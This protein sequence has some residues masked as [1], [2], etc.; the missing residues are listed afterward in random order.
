[1]IPVFEIINETTNMKKFKACIKKPNNNNYIYQVCYCL[2]NKLSNHPSIEQKELILD[3]LQFLIKNII[4]KKN[5]EFI[6]VKTYTQQIKPRTDIIKYILDQIYDG[7]SD[8]TKFTDIEPEDEKIMYNDRDII[9]SQFID[10]IRELFNIG[11]IPT[12]HHQCLDLYKDFVKIN[13]SLIS[14]R[15]IEN[16]QKYLP[17]FEK[18]ILNPKSEALKLVLTGIIDIE[19]KEGAF[20]KFLSIYYL[21]GEKKRMN[22][23]QFILFLNKMVFPVFR[24]NKTIFTNKIVSLNNLSYG[25]YQPMMDT[26][27]DLG[28]LY[29][30]KDGEMEDFF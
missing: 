19:T 20:G 11:F 6:I 10:N 28:V 29:S 25:S 3:K 7:N 14:N 26:I 18:Y 15:L 23:N 12:C 4:S 5:V 24:N 16:A 9:T 2:L 13:R 1:M 8:D 21:L 27:N 22:T 17:Q 30:F